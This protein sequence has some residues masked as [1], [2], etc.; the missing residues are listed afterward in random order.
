M[1]LGVPTYGSSVLDVLGVENVCAASA[2]PVV[3]LDEARALQP[4]LVL[5]PSEPYP[6]SERHRAELESVGPVLFVDGKD[7]FWWGVRTRGAIG[8]LAAAIGE[9]RFR[10]T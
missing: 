8:R 3:S 4:D 9:V 1:A 10:L 6:F 5:A 2:Y 7:L